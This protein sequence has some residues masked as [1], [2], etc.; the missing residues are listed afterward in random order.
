MIYS[1]FVVASTKKKQYSLSGCIGGVYK[2]Q[3][4]KL[5]L[6]Q[7]AEFLELSL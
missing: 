3:V 4:N 2:R 5:E 1:S 6:E 7:S